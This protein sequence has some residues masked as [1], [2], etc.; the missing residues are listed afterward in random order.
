M[1]KDNNSSN[2]QNTQNNVP[3]QNAAPEMPALNQNQTAQPNVDMNNVKSVFEDMN[4]STQ[5]TE[6]PMMNNAPIN[7]TQEPSV[8]QTPQVEIPDDSVNVGSTTIG[9]IKPDKQKSP[10]SML[11]LFGVLL[12]FILF[13]PEVLNF[14]NEKFGTNF[15]THTGVKVNEEQV[16]DQEEEQR[17]QMYDLDE[18]TV[19]T[20]DKISFQSFTKTISDNEYKLSLEAKNSGTQPYEF[21]KKVYLDFFDANSTFVGRAYLEDVKSI[22]GGITNNYVVAIDKEIYD[23]A[24]K[25]ELIQRTTVDYPEVTLVSNQLTC[26]NSKFNI[27]YTFSESQ[28]LSTIRDVFTY[29]NIG[30]IV[31]DSDAQ[32]S[33]KSKISNLD[34]LD[35]VTGVLKETDTGFMTTIYIDY[36]SADYSKLSSDTNYYEKDTYAK[37]IKFEMSAK[38][39]NCR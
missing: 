11:V 31:A 3:T 24:K 8:P 30:D 34:D 39:Y 1:D 15:D 2:V 12:C 6:A 17:V 5:A 35:G 10:I 21:K 16:V 13:M 36:K 7:Q 27:V 18:K 23:K 28:R 25:V 14:V 20:V 37:I 19:I 4:V 22:T 32:I 29:T 26:T 38:G 9:T 33:Y